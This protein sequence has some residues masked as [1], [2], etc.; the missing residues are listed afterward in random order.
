M[1]EMA[2]IGDVRAEARRD[3]RVPIGAVALRA[4][5]FQGDAGDACGVDGQMRPLLGDEASH[6][7]R[8]GLA[9]GD[10]RIGE[11]VEIDAVADHQ[12]LV[13]ERQPLARQGFR[14]GGEGHV[15]RPRLHAA[16]E[17]LEGRRVQRRHHRRAKVAGAQQR[18]VMQAVV[19]NDVEVA[20]RHI[21]HH[22]LVGGELGAV[23]PQGGFVVDGAAGGRA[24]RLQASARI[25]PFG[26]VERHAVPAGTQGAREQMSVHLEPSRE[27]LGDGIF[28][29]GEQGDLHGAAD[30]TSRVSYAASDAADGHW[31]A[32][33]V[34]F[35]ATVR[36]AKASTV[37][38]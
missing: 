11:G 35:D 1:A 14:N 12:R 20:A 24:D 32:P 23:D 22:R 33:T 27:G 28:E 26:G 25:R 18:Q 3:L 4:G 34:P 5:E 37:L 29:V 2:E 38:I 10:G 19:V 6:P 17:G 31:N 16:H 15:V 9:L 8:M 21:R 30:I 13:D 7:D 36:P